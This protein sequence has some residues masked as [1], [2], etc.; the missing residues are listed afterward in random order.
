MCTGKFACTWLQIFNASNSGDKMTKLEEAMQLYEEI[1]AECKIL[2]KKLDDLRELEL[3]CQD[4]PDDCIDNDMWNEW[5]Y[6]EWV[7]V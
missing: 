2:K 5:T 4:H 1:Q 3:E 7:G 6:D